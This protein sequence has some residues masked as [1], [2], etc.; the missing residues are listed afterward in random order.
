MLI[1]EKTLGDL[2]GWQAMKSAR[3]RVMLG[4]VENSA[5]EG[6]VFRGVVREGKRK[7]AVSLDVQGPTK[8]EC[9]CS[10]VDAQARGLV[11]AHA[12]AVALTELQKGQTPS[13]MPKPIESKVAS[14]RAVSSKPVRPGKF[15]VWIPSE[16]IE[17]AARNGRLPVFL[18]FQPGGEET[19]PLSVWLAA[20]GI[21]AQTGP[22]SLEPATLDGFLSALDG[23]PRVWD[24]R[25]GAAVEKRKKITVGEDAAGMLAIHAEFT[26]PKSVTFS[27]EASHTPR[28]GAFLTADQTPSANA[29]INAAD[30]AH[31]VEGFLTAVRNTPLLVAGDRW[32]FQKESLTL[33]PLS[34]S[35]PEV[36]KLIHE[37]LAKT[38]GGVVR[39]L[40]WLA[41]WLDA[42]E[43]TVN[44]ETD[45]ALSHLRLV[46]AEPQFI[47]ELDGSPRQATAR[48]QAQV[49]P[50]R[51]SIRPQQPER[52][53]HL[54]P[55]QAEGGGLV[56]YQRNMA[57]ESRLRA[58]LEA[59]GFAA[60][61]SDDWE[62]RGEREVAEFFASALPRLERKYQVVTT[63][64]WRSAFSGWRRIAPLVKSRGD[65]SPPASTGSAFGGPSRGWLDME[66][67]YQSADGF[68]IPRNEVL[69]LLR[70]KQSAVR[71]KQGQVYVLD[72]E[73]CD[74]FESLIS[75]S[76]ARLG[77]NGGL[78]LSADNQ[79]ILNDYYV[80]N[81]PLARLALPELAEVK[82]RLGDLVDR[83]RDYQI[84]GVRWLIAAAESGR[85][86]LLADDMG[87]GK[88]LQVLALLR[89]LKPVSNPVNN[90]MQSGPVLI[91]CPTSLLGNWEAELQKFAPELRYKINHG[92]DRQL[93]EDNNS[94]FD[95]I[96]TTY[97]LLVNDLTEYCKINLAG[98]VLDEAGYIRNPDTAA[99]KAACQLRVPVRVAL[100]GTPVEN[101]VRDLWSIMRFVQ[102]GFLGDRKDFEDRYAKPLASAATDPADS[103]RL[104]R[105]LRTRLGPFVLRRTKKEV[106]RELP[107]KVE[108]VIFCELSAQ[109]KEVYRRV[110]EEGQEEIRQ[111]R[112]R[113]G[114][115]SARMTMFTV[116]LRL[117]QIC[118]DLRLIGDVARL[119]RVEPSVS[120]AA[121]STSG[122]VFSAE[123]LSQA[124]P[125]PA[126]ESQATGGKWEALSDIVSDALPGG[127]KILMF[128]QFTGM[129]KLARTWLEE[130]GIGLSY[131]D[132]STRNRTAEVVAFQTDPAR[133]V[134]LISLKAGGYGLNLTAAD[135]VVLL[136]PWWNPAVEA[137][138]I[139]RAHRIGQASI[140]TA[141]RLI[142]RGT[143]EERILK[144]QAT[145]RQIMA[146]A[147]EDDPLTLP[148]LTEDDLAALLD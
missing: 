98:L 133:K 13:V 118:N 83:L 87:L 48:V 114:A 1:T 22:L 41:S 37:C 67:S 4:T 49:G 52:E 51:H 123:N 25:P 27:F 6:D 10:C 115:G 88:T 113:S 125:D 30:F 61:A 130:Q 77:D 126:L 53:N 81:Q 143:V 33:A 72:S 35:S 43:Q 86:A 101:S 73:S 15:D 26:Q 102:P 57:R 119:S 34:A 29:P 108:K 141:S 80:K 142:A 39:D 109:Q 28:N 122:H 23:H 145:K 63:D 136:E 128:S 14:P 106:V 78:A 12:L 74:D 50:V 45:E 20:Q 103:G 75:E 132:G 46:L 2:G 9:R 18:Q 116:L 84:E 5:R 69:R 110:L 79:H 89:W 65:S 104:L 58:E 94:I 38:S 97:S 105:R 120:Q 148:G 139:D 55:I 19:D 17:T 107:D 11:C 36:T 82:R 3:E 95:V 70:S 99:A 129:L 71:G 7:F 68:S 16:K 147:V 137:Q 121:N 64:R 90:L 32:L 56:F 134:F 60:R 59:M 144:L 96:L 76:G 138:A 44:L 124:P 92:I 62:L 135:H 112:R 100:S 111:A 131:L 31:S 8:A 40:R 47:I 21:D 91:I 127:H 117:R 42:I 85:G 24:G 93:L 146:S 140:V 54:Y 66:F